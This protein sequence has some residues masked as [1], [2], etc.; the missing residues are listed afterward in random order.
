MYQAEKVKIDVDMAEQFMRM[1]NL[2]MSE[3]GQ[4]MGRCRSWWFGIRKA[5]GYMTKNA[6]NLMCHV[7]GMNYDKVVIPE[8]NITINT[9]PSEGQKPLYSDDESIQGIVNSMN[10]IELTVKRIELQMRTIL[11]ELGVK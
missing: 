4:K 2:T 7:L 5:D 11:K 3:F 8:P 9:T 10:T 1:H 6:A